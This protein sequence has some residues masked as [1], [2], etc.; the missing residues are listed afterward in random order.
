MRLRFYE[1]SAAGPAPVTSEAL[2][3]IAELYR[4]EDDIRSRTQEERRTV[5]QEKSRPIADSL[6][7]WL[8]EQLTLVS[9]K[10]KLAEA[11]RYTLSRLDGL[12]RRGV[13]SSGHTARG[14]F[15]DL[16]L[17]VSD[18]RLGRH[19]DGA[20][21]REIGLGGSSTRFRCR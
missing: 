10:T 4:I 6:A 3:R 9:Q 15:G 13:R 14:A 12:T 20:H 1:L 16:E 17:E 5:Q 8:T 19:H 11:I 2:R 7:S 21:L 18:H